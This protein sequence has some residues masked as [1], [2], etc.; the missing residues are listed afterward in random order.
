MC[1]LGRLHTKRYFPL[2]SFGYT[3][4]GETRQ[5]KARGT[6]AEALPK[7]SAEE[8]RQIRAKLNEL[9]ATEWVD[10]GTFCGL[11]ANAETIR[12]IP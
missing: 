6:D 7:L 4:T 2:N 11:E 3:Q 8:R 10:E 12:R 5:S 9:D 1:A